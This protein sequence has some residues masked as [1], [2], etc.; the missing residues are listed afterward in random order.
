MPNASIVI[1]SYNHAAYLPDAIT[2]ALAQTVPCEVIVVDDGSTD[3]TPAV[4]DRFKDHI[5][6][7]L[8]PHRGP[9]TARNAGLDAAT[10]DF[11][12]WLDA[13]DVIAPGKVARQIQELSDS[14][15]SGWVLC[16]VEIQD[17]AKSRRELASAR[18]GYAA[19]DLSGWICDQLDVANFIPIMSPLVRRATLEDIRFKD[20]V[21]G[22]PE[23]WRFWQRV[24]K[25]ARVRYVPEVLAT[26]RKRRTGRNRLPKKARAVVPNIESPLRLNLGCGTPNTRSWH[27]MPWFVNLDKSLDW[28]FEDGLADFVDGSV[29]GITISHA[30]MYVA[31]PDW[32]RVFAEFARV[33]QPGG[34]IRITEDET[35]DPQSARHPHGWQGSQPAVTLTHPAMV[36]SALERAGFVAYDVSATTT[37]F[38]D[39]SLCQA[40]HGEAPTVFF[41]EGVRPSVVLFAPHSDDETLFAA[42]TILRYRPHVVICFP[43]AGDYGDTGMREAETRDA[44]TVLG[45]RTVEQWNGGDL[46]S[47]MRA[48]DR[49]TVPTLV[50]APDRRTSHLDHLSVAA[51]A[52]A[53]FGDR[54]RTYHTYDASGKVTSDQRV[55]HEPIWVQQK[56][57]ALAR[58]TSQITHPRANQFFLNDLHEYLGEA[59]P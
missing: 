36:R 23:D 57:R 39:Q 53:V 59:R 34:V 10:S 25:V 9:S 51:A 17:E 15:E 27:P 40:Q 19:R 29:A 32:P 52:A 5:R 46:V 35:K 22:E 6:A 44:M 54:L 1:P 8:Q 58:Y 18:Y 12:M 21:D 37:H 24:A 16:D 13:D 38:A 7:I 42:F 14:P 4:L 2:S 11:V 50:F 49:R 56:L 28:R 48:L 3:N 55:P 45:G 33:L 30:L 20:T 47:P 41:I 31:E 26:Y 43:S